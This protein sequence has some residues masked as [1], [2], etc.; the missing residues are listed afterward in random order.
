MISRSPIRLRK[1]KIVSRFYVRVRTKFHLVLAVTSAQVRKQLV[2]EE[3]AAARL[4]EI[5]AHDVS[6]SALIHTGME[7]EDYQ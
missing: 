3:E 7:L 1:L 6:P 5:A 2:Q 4:G